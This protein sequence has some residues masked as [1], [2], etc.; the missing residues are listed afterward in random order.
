M[1]AKECLQPTRTESSWPFMGEMYFG[2]SLGGDTE[3]LKKELGV[4]EG[5]RS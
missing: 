2:F 4:L 3:L 5:D 1:C